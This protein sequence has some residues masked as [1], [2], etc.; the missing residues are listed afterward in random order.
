MEVTIYIGFKLD[1]GWVDER[2]EEYGVYWLF[3]GPQEQ[4]KTQSSCLG[5]S[6]K[7]VFKIF[8]NKYIVGWGM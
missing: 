5:F 2:Q 4:Q 1:T 3:S 8:L 7:L 6:A